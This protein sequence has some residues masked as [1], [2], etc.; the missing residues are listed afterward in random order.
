MSSKYFR[1]GEKVKHGDGR[2]GIVVRPVG[3]GAI[4][5]RWSDGTEEAVRMEDLTPIGNHR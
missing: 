2:V 5:V 3:S 1:S 4:A